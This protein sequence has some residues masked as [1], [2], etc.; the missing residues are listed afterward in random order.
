MDQASNDAGWRGST[1]GW[2]DA[3]YGALLGIRRRVGEDPAAGETAEPVAHELLLVL[4]GSR[5]VARA[6]WSRWRDKNTG[7]L[8]R[9]SEAY[10]ESVAEAVLNVFDCWLDRSLFDSQFE[11]AI[12]SWAL[13][14]P[15]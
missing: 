3:A 5:G 8:V 9:Q 13:Q 11:F 7:S 12:R 10:A 6:R 14:S 2:L 15:I 1:E 4:Q